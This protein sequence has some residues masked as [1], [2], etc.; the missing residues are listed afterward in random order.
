VAARRSRT[1]FPHE[2]FFN[3]IAPIPAAAGKIER[4]P[5]PK[6]MSYFNLLYGILR[7]FAGMVSEAGPRERPLRS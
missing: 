1:A 6:N 3:Y 4:P 7:D 5:Q 2:F